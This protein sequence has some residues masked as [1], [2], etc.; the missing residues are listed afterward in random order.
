MAVVVVLCVV[1]WGLAAAGSVA[2]SEHSGA[3]GDD[4]GGFY[5]AS[6]DALAAEGILEGTECGQARICPEEPMPRRVMAVWL[7]RAL[8]ETDPESVE[9]SRFDDVD[10]ESWWAPF[11]ERLFELEVTRGCSS[12]VGPSYCPDDSVTR[13]QMAVLLTRAFALPEAPDAGFGDIDNNFARQQINALAAA[14][15]TAGCGR[16]SP[17]Y[18]PNDVVTRGQ[19]AVF[20]ARALGLTELPDSVRFIAVDAGG[21]HTC[22]VRA[23][24]TAVCWG[25]NNYGQAEPPEGRFA[26][27]ASGSIHSCGLRADKTIMCWGSKNSDQTEA[28][29]GTFDALSAG[30]NHSCALQAKGTPGGGIVCWGDSASGQLDAPDGQF[31]ALSAG[32]THNCGLRV[33]N[34]VTCWGSNEYGQI[35]PPGG[36]FTAVA[37][38]YWH[39]CGLR[40]NGSIACW[41]VANPSLDDGQTIV[42]PG[43]FEAVSTGGRHSCGLRTNGS[44]TC[45]GSNYGGQTEAPAGQFEAVSAGGEHSCGLR[46]DAV[47]VCW[48]NVP[49]RRASAPISEFGSVVAAVDYSCGLRVEGTIACWGD[50]IYGQTY[51]ATGRF[52]HLAAGERNA[53]A[54][55]ADTTV[56]CWGQNLRGEANAPAGR[57]SA[58]AVGRHDSC[59]LLI[60]S[61]IT[62]W[63]DFSSLTAT[64]RG[65][66]SE[67]SAGE[68]HMCGLRISGTVA[69]WGQNRDGRAD[70]P[71]GNFQSVS[72]GHRHSCALQVGRS[73]DC[74]GDNGLGQSDAPS[75]A[76]SAVS[77]GGSHSCGLRGDATVICW[78]D[79][80]FGQ[81]DAPHGP[82]VAVSAGARHTCGLR[83]DAKVACWG[84]RSI[85]PVPAGA[86]M[87]R[88]IRS[89]DPNACRPFGQ[90][91]S[92]TGFPLPGLVPTTGTVRVAVLFVDF[93]DAPAPYSTQLESINSLSH[94]RD[95]FRAASYGKM[96]LEF[97]PHYRWLRAEHSYSR[98]LGTTPVGGSAITEINREAVRLADPDFDFTG[99]DA[100]MIVMPSAQF[101][102]GN[103]GGHVLTDEA[104]RVRAFRINTYPYRSGAGVI[105]WG[106]TA[107]H[108]FAH[109]LG[110]A[111]LYPFAAN[112]HFQPTIAPE[113]KRWRRTELGLMGLAAYMPVADQ[114]PRSNTQADE[115][116]AWSRWQ[117]GWLDADQVRCIRDDQETVDLGPV[118]DPGDGIA[119]AAIPLSSTDVIVL[120]SRRKIGYDKY[121][122]LAN[123]GV[124]V[125]TVDADIDSGDLPIKVA[126]DT[127]RGNTYEYPILDAGQS[128]TVRGYTITVVSD[129][130]A[131]HTV[132]ITRDA[133]A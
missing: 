10:A 68:D 38:G 127:G 17:S 44:I 18:C 67:I 113:G 69:C 36:A 23:D 117:L 80:K 14:G 11:V 121:A 129:D 101:L 125:Y 54:V 20:L 51:E 87:L 116:L 128:V 104:F 21:G 84:R 35:D 133:D 33:D 94:V 63:G 58:V 1:S 40:A 103:A 8:D 75:G 118:S 27:V 9:S 108:E 50:N 30:G 12:A 4:E 39:S 92:T 70:A 28:P 86:M 81:S 105:K 122:A 5:E 97:V 93:R 42:P 31:I 52:I 98:Y 109:V 24:N 82:F 90:P 79:N 126:G 132:E 102:G 91:R 89:P 71:E 57:F 74:W 120:E 110:L 112:R 62:C 55:R 59:G 13:A 16:D 130:G 99:T 96:R 73:I 45:W 115:M 34:T 32:A 131:T 2:A 43:K 114:D 77:A 85:V 29:V 47:V 107:A 3:F 46:A 119:M 78:G 15:I 83:S 111:D 53:C 106:A 19:M 61:T 26:E 100:V 64:P 124:L 25:Q 66:F 56:L 37:A 48:G 7:V 72:A 60:D 76:F 65:A 88:W 49:A 22:A 41:G 95:Y 6:L 123:E